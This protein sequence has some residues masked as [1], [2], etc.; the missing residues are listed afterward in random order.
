M[1]GLLEVSVA[2]IGNVDS[3]KSTLT[4]VLTN[5]KLDNGNGSARL[6]VSQHKHEKDSGR[7]SSVSYHYMKHKKGVVIFLDLAGHSKYF[8]STCYGLNSYI[9]YAMLTIDGNKGLKIMTLEHMR[10]ANTLKKK[11]FIVITKIDKVDMSLLKKNIKRLREILKRLNK[12]I[13]IIKKES[14]VNTAINMISNNSPF[15][16]VFFVSNKKGDE[17]DP[18]MKFLRNFLSKLEPIYTWSNNTTKDTLFYVDRPYHVKGVGLVVSGIVKNGVIKNKEILYL[19]PI[20]GCFI[21]ITVK[22]IHNNFKEL[23]G[24]LKCGNSGC[25]AIRSKNLT[26]ES[27]LKGVVVTSKPVKL[28]NTFL[29]DVMIFSH[30]TTI[31]R[32]YQSIINCGTI[33]QA[34][35]VIDIK[36]TKGDSLELIRSGDKAKVVFKLVLSAQFIEKDRIFT[37]R[38]GTTRGAGII[39]EFLS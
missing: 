2:V 22:S 26:K 17:I 7:T 16:P 39:L 31:T 5:G 37:F 1:D 14:D 23:I 38:E 11:L 18:P 13:I 34:V 24:E 9:D 21:E 6:L 12:K 15:I 4:S 10:T 30:S 25:L 33:Q 20:K 27:I 3:G 28:V 29:A 32:G 8:A 19:G 36:N 35:K